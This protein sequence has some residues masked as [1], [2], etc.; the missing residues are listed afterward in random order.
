M[1]KTREQI[2]EELASLN[3]VSCGTHGVF[4]YCAIDGNRFCRSCWSKHIT[5]HR[6][7]GHLSLEGIY[8]EEGIDT[9]LESKIKKLGEEL[10]S[11]SQ[12]IKKD[13]G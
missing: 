5:G 13:W 12:K 11:L 7:G 3:C 1:A 2:V 9:E 10:A 4:Y 6:E 8:T